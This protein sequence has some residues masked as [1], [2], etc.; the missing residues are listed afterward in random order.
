LSLEPDAYE[1]ASTPLDGEAPALDEAEA[2][3][4][5]LLWMAECGLIRTSRAF[6]DAVR[7]I[8]PGAEAMSPSD[9]AERRQFFF[10]V[11]QCRDANAVAYS[12]RRRR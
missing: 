3:A 7:A 9:A 5:T 11:E 12:G 2:E 8:W 10:E 4:L 1:A 6:P